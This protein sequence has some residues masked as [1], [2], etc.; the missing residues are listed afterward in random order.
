MSETVRVV[1][2]WHDAVNA[3]EIEQVL[4]L[5][6]PDVA[7]AGPRGTA[8]GHDVMR[9]WL[10]RSGIQ[11]EPQ[12]P[13]VERDG[14]VVVRELAR[15]RTSEPAPSGAPVQDPAETWV[16]FGVTDGLVSL[17]RRYETADEVPPG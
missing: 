16:E 4:R 7:V 3:E 12:E 1:G 2:E 13:M 11:L 5:C 10:Q 15:W 6:A 17:V 9:A 8:R 14:R